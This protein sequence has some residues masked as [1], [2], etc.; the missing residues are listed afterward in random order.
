VCVGVPA[1]HTMATDKPQGVNEDETLIYQEGRQ[2][3]DD[4]YI[5]GVLENLEANTLSFAAW[6]LESSDA[7]RITFPFAQFDELF[8]TNPDLR[9]GKNRDARFHWVIVRLDFHSDGVGGRKLILGA[10]PTPED[11]EIG[12]PSSLGTGRMTYAER[13]RLRFETE[14]LD[15]KRAQNIA[16]K[17]DKARK[18]FLQ[19]LQ[20]KRKMEQLKAAA[21]QKRIE[22]ERRERREHRALEKR[23]KEERQ[24]R[25]KEND[26]KRNHAIQQVEADRAKRDDERIRGVIEED[27]KRKKERKLFIEEAKQK[28][29]EE[30]E[31]AKRIEQEQAA[32]NA[33][34]ESRREDK[35]Q[36]R[37]NNYAARERLYLVNRQKAIDDISKQRQLKA[38]RKAQYLYQKS[39]ERAKRLKEE[40]ERAAEWERLEDQ[41]EQAELKREHD[42]NMSMLVRI[43]ELKAKKAKEDEQMRQRK[44]NA[45][46]R[47]RL[48]EKAQLDLVATEARRAAELEEKRAR[49]IA[50]REGVREQRHQDYVQM[51]QEQKQAQEAKQREKQKQ[52]NNT[53]D[54]SRD[55][56]A[57]KRRQ[58]VEED[59]KLEELKRKREANIATQQ[60]N[61][62]M[63]ELEKVKSHRET[64]DKKHLELEACKMQKRLAEKELAQKHQEDAI[65]KSKQWNSL[66]QRRVEAQDKKEQDRVTR[67]KNRRD[68]ANAT[69]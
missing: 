9:S 19:E 18:A 43:E 38:E 8:A 49:A 13:Q 6:E 2:I 36:D 17:S 58:K 56:R 53:R 21:R 42:R 33:A 39:A 47:R 24:Q 41:R 1:I 69:A 63:S 59:M 7:Q 45:L 46:E 48:Q 54:K 37:R 65:E 64:Q 52:L 31:T 11:P 40:H 50:T 20:D 61:R 62:D 12:V 22:D 25:Y 4:F 60:R 44:E 67:E 5:C 57:E 66:E 30:Q 3:N 55:D 27:R 14:R 51:I 15:E 68:F 23:A 35:I 28:K 32:R 10:E 16:A 29:R 26:E 34:L